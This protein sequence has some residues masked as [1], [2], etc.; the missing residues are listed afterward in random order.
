MP[1][2]VSHVGGSTTMYTLAQ[3]CLAL[4]PRLNQRLQAGN[5]RSY[6][7]HSDEGEAGQV[8][9]L[10]TISARDPQI[11]AIAHLFQAEL[12]LRSPYRCGEQ[13]QRGSL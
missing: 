3:T 8:E 5:S 9:L 12:R 11:D 7:L 2:V 4:I 1:F 13:T 10:N 6:L